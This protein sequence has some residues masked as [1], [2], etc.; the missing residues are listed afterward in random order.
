MEASGRP[1]V[2]GE[3]EEEGRE[4]REDPS[5]VREGGDSLQLGEESGY[6]LDESLRE[7][8]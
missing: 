3:E 7:R 5:R 8:T 4:E 2:V 1:F 6:R